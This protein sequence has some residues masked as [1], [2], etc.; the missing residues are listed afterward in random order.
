VNENGGSVSISVTR[1][2][3]SSGAVG[4]SYAT[5]NGT[6][7]AGSDYIST[8]GSLSWANGDNATKSFSVS[9]TDDST[10]E[11]DETFTMTLSGSSG[12][13]SVGSP[14]TA[15][16]TIIE[17]DPLPPATGLVGEWLFN[18]NAIDT[19]GYGNNGTLHGA[20]LTADRFANTNSAF[21]F[22][23]S[24]YIDVHNSASLNPTQAISVVAWFYLR[25]LAGSYPPIVKK[26]G[27][28][29]SQPHGYSLEC[30]PDPGGS[31][32][33]YVGPSV[34]FGVDNNGSGGTGSIFAPIT[35]NAW[36]F[37]VGVYDGSSI[38]LYVDGVL[39]SSD[40][41]TGNLFA[42]SNDLNIGRDPSNPSRL[43]DCKIDDV[44][45]YNRALSDAEIQELFHEG[46]WSEPT[47]SF[48]FTDPGNWQ[49]FDPA[50]IG[51]GS[52]VAYT[53]GVWDGRYVYFI[54]N[55]QGPSDPAFS[56]VL[57]YDTTQAFSSGAAWATFDP[58]ANG[59]GTPA[60]GGSTGGTFDGRYLYLAPLRGQVLRY[61]TQAPFGST[62]SW[63]VYDLGVVA[64]YRGAVYNGRYVYFSPGSY[65]GGAYGVALRYDTQASFTSAAGWTA[66]DPGANGVGADPRGFVGEVFDGRYVYYVPHDNGS[67]GWFGEVLRYDTQATFG[68]PSGWAAFDPGANGV[69][70]DPDGY[71]GGVFD[72]RYV[73][74]V[75]YINDALS[76]S[77]E[78]L[79]YDTQSSFESTSAWTAYDVDSFAAGGY[80]GATF[81][82]KYLYFAPNDSL[83]VLRYDTSAPFATASSWSTFDLGTSG[84]ATNLSR[85]AGAV[86]DGEYV[87]FVPYQYA[88]P[89]KAQVV[90]FHA[91]YPAAI[92]A[93]I[94]G[95]ST[96]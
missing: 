84:I 14:G 74:F 67:Y 93:T 60:K 30:H 28:G 94:V 80:W 58:P 13:A 48:S 15:T 87:Y 57:R 42:S 69:G 46:G 59:V 32:G 86:F 36:H 12:G 61:D 65:A 92:P 21:D 2:G 72:G 73:Y 81:D 20:T 76:P 50:I 16:V 85:F 24:S 66:F 51:V 78:V 23:G 70:S 5:S 38:K 56:Q 39:R 90:R 83:E 71:A 45:I 1:T 53:G 47:A 52:D 75:P 96:Y 37:A 10:Y 33:P 55:N 95:G 17:N 44:R 19:S 82:G 22:N 89:E 62:S 79:R 26:T 34:M 27:E 9:I 88:S 63:A 49:A 8:S 35:L 77:G 29:F 11:A 43:S 91:R 64:S 25:S 40:A 41:R 18:G 6:A 7:T 3:G 68:A 54:P 4:V 31:A